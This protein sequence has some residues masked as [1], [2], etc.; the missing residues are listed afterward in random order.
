EERRVPGDA[1]ARSADD[2]ADA[3]HFFSEH[4]PRERARR[5][6]LV[7]ILRSRNQDPEDGKEREDRDQQRNADGASGNERI[8]LEV[9][10]A[11]KPQR[12]E[13]R[14]GGQ[15]EECAQAH[16]VLSGGKRRQHR[17]ERL[18]VPPRRTDDET[19]AKRIDEAESADRD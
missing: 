11:G 3:P 19:L 8:A 15:R 1:A 5:Q 13:H 9:A 18:E 14:K 2:A 12:K 10:A 7:R 4:A 16:P 6:R 17:L